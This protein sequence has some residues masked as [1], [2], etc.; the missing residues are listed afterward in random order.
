MKTLQQKETDRPLILDE[1]ADKEI[2]QYLLLLCE[3]GGAVNCAIVRA[4]AMGIIGRKNSN[5]LA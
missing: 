2:Q 5:L 4:S 1:E 3:A